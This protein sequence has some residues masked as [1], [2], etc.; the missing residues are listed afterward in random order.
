MS[1]NPLGGTSSGGFLYYQR[2]IFWG[3]VQPVGV[4]SYGALFAEMLSHEPQEVGHIIYSSRARG[5]VGLIFVVA[6]LSVNLK[7]Y[8]EYVGYEIACYAD[9]VVAFIG[10]FCIVA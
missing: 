1:S 2:Q 5:L 9:A 3:D 7:Q 4:I 6:V 8:I 10:H